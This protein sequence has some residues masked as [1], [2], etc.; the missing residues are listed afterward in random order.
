MKRALEEFIVEGIHT[1]I[2][3]HLQLMDDPNFLSGNFNTHYLESEFTFDPKKG[4]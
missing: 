2:P 4:E 1:T 3:Y